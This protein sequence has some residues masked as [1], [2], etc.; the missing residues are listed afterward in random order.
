MLGNCPVQL[1]GTVDPPFKRFEC[2]KSRAAFWPTTAAAQHSTHPKNNITHFAGC[3][4]TRTTSFCSCQTAAAAAAAMNSTFVRN[5]R[6]VIEEKLD[7]TTRA[8]EGDGEGK[9]RRSIGEDL[10]SPVVSYSFHRMHERFTCHYCVRGTFRRGLP[11]RG[12]DEPACF[13]A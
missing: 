9:E 5:I 6:P 10:R 3:R 1:P 2:W 13:L 4:P 7:T 12:I 11:P 8:H